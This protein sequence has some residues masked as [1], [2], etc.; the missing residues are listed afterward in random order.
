LANS[1]KHAGA[2]SRKVR[3][4]A[5]DSQVEVTIS[6]DGSG[7]EPAEVADG[8]TLGLVGMRERVELL[9]GSF[10]VESRR[11]EGTEIQAVLPLTST[12]ASV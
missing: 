2:A 3:A 8:A 4:T 5:T 1:Y 6:D 12:V 7:F 10:S 11:R 9:G